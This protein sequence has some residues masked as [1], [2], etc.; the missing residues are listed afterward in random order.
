MA[1]SLATTRAALATALGTITGL[2]V[3]A[4]LAP[5][6]QGLTAMV[7]APTSG[8]L[9]ESFGDPSQGSHDWEIWLLYPGAEWVKAQTAI[10]PYLT[11]SGASSISAALNANATLAGKLG[12]IRYRDYGPVEWAGAAYFGVSILVTVLE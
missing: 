9:E 6:V 7:G 8:D 3:S 1:N 5:S 11:Q 2:R 12:P 10:D 4:Y